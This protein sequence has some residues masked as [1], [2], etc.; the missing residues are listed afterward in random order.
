MVIKM[1]S[2]LERD[3]DFVYQKSGM[4]VILAT[5]AYFSFECTRNKESLTIAMIL[6]YLIPV[7]VCFM[8][9]AIYR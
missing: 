9:N 4:G 8:V 1:V 3:K 6:V 5:L 2:H 7:L